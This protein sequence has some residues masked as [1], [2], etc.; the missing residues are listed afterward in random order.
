M[1]TNTVYNIIILLYNNCHITQLRSKLCKALPDWQDLAISWHS[2]T[3]EI[4]GS[5]WIGNVMQAGQALEGH[6]RPMHTFSIFADGTE[7][8]AE[9]ASS[10]SIVSSLAAGSRHGFLPSCRGDQLGSV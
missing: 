7:A 3:S 6:P 9:G 8:E 5:P 2:M 1:I 4:Q 10:T